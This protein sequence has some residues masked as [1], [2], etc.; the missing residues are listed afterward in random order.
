MVA[1]RYIAKRRKLY[2]ESMFP[3][4]AWTSLEVLMIYGIGGK[5]LDATNSFFI[6]SRACVKAEGRFSESLEI[7]M[8]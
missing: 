2:A 7:S 3:E 1:E 4:K 5:L 6:N 8:G